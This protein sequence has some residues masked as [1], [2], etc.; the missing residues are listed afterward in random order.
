VELH[1]RVVANGHGQRPPVGTPVRIEVRDVTEQDAASTLIVAAD[2]RVDAIG[3]PGDDGGAAL[4]T[5]VLD[6]ADDAVTPQRDLILWAR[7]AASGT[8]RVA[9]GDWITMQ[10]VPVRPTGAAA[11]PVQDIEVRPVA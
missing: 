5:A 7:V 10:S 3:D 4:A 1:V 9:V 6:L 8:E 11:P 2:T